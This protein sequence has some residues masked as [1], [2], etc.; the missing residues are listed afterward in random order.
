MVTKAN[1]LL[2][3]IATIIDN[4]CVVIIPIG[5]LIN[6]GM[7]KYNAIKLAGLIYIIYSISIPVLTK[8]FTIGKYLMGIRITKDDYTY[9]SPIQ[10]FLR[11]FAKLAYSIPLVGIVLVLISSYLINKR[12]DGK[13]LH[14][15]V[16][17]TIVTN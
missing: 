7:D 15:I 5:A 13:A 17:K 2:R 1:V 12:A 6:S 4:T 3:V 9:T 8:G 11:E 14:D 16:A 10:I